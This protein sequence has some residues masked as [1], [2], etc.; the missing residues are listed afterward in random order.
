MSAKE[1]QDTTLLP[2]A[3]S[4]QELDRFLENVPSR[5]NPPPA[6]NKK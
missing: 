6:K 1:R 2:K 5:E 3:F 4:D